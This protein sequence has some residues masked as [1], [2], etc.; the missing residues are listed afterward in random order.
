MGRLGFFLVGENSLSPFKISFMDIEFDSL[1][2]HDKYIR[3]FVGGPNEKV[4]I[5]D[6]GQKQ[7]GAW[8][9]FMNYVCSSK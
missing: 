2:K 9:K 6:F 4:F 7:I 5:L 3:F 8:S 1:Q